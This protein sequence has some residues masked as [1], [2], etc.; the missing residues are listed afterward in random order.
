MQRST[1]W[2]GWIALIAPLHMSEQ[3][4]FGID[5]LARLRRVL[6]VYYSW[7]QQPDYGTVV[8][9]A[10]VGTLLLG[11]TYG[12]LAGGLLKEI[13]LSIWA[14]LA[15]GE[16]HHIVET[17]AAGRYT[18]GT[19]TAIPYVT[20][21]ILLMFSIVREHRQRGQAT[22]SAA[23]S[24]TDRG[25]KRRGFVRRSLVRTNLSTPGRVHHPQCAHLR[26]IACDSK[27]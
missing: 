25:R 9:V 22:S 4:L 21:G 11:L 26:R 8:L 3:L 6:A 24:A 10:V 14:L 19:A 1:R 23:S 20:F 13:S 12:I 5:E 16:V 2:F 7:F 18:P 17:I 27:G 15:V